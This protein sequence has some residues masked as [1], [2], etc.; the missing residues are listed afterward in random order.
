MVEA[1]AWRLGVFGKI[2]QT[3]LLGLYARKKIERRRATITKECDIG[4]RGLLLLYRIGSQ[5]W[6]PAPL[7]R[8]V[9]K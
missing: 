9:L 1:L 7:L 2:L 4:M 8:K 6:F 5:A 3:P